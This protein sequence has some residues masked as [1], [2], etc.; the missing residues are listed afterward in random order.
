MSRIVVGTRGS[1]LALAQ[2][3][4]VVRRL[5][6]TGSEVEILV[7][8][9]RGDRGR[10][11]P[12][13]GSF[14][15]ELERVL[16]EGACDLAVHSAKDLPARPSPGFR[17]AYPPREDAR[18]A[19]VCPGAGDL[20][21]LPSGARVGTS[22]PRRRAQLLRLRPD[23]HVV[24]IRGNLDTRLEKVR[25]G[26]VDAVVVA[27]AGLRRLGMEGE[28]AFVLSPEEML[29]APGQGALAVQARD[30]DPAAALLATLDDVPTR[31]RV[32]AE[33]A[34]LRALAGGCSL[35]L[36]V[37]SACDGERLALEAAVFSPD[38]GCVVRAAAEG[39][40]SEPEAVGAG[41][42]RRL[43]ARGAARIAEGGRGV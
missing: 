35:P 20:A 19:V 22:S 25:R 32:E 36:G 16:E 30:D 23:L 27:L 31:A 33:R 9:T 7:V 14:T 13:A 39:E 17:L 34:L 43:L 10:R 2:A 5:A 37:C 1:P 41:V 21:S 6:G 8:R 24:P 29:P 11:S 38:G 42:A 40:A 15:A 12:E 3:E 26:E 28:A 18:D 4:E